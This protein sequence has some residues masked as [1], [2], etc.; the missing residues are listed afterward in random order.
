MNIKALAVGIAVL[1]VALVTATA[2]LTQLSSGCGQPSQV[3]GKGSTQPGV[4]EVVNANNQF[5][6]E[7]YCLSKDDPENEDS[8]LFFSPYSISTALAMTYEGARGITAEEMQS[9]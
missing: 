4:Q 9:V 2:V 1:A 8:N 5:A 7:L 6:L 3:D